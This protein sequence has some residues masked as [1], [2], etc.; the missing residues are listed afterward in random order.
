MAVIPALASGL[1][2]QAEAGQYMAYNN[3]TTALPSAVAPLLFGAMLNAGGA[4]TPASFVALLVVA[5]AF[6]LVGGV[7][8]EG[9]V[10]QKALAAALH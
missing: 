8:F 9:R 1:A 2:P 3:L 5:A 10:S 6:Y 7:L 4:S